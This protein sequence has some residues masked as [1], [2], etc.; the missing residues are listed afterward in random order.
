LGLD[1]ATLGGSG[2]KLEQLS[3][4]G[5]SSGLEAN[6]DHA[7]QIAQQALTYVSNLESLLERAS[8]QGV[9]S[10]AKSSKMSAADALRTA[11]AI[12]NTVRDTF[13]VP[14]GLSSLDPRLVFDLLSATQH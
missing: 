2:G 4:Q 8:L 11:Q 7:V 6:A 14:L 3:T 1:A 5:R 10:A 12:R 13:A 9:K